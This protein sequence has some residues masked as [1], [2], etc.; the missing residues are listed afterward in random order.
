[1]YSRVACAGVVVLPGR[2]HEVDRLRVVVDVDR[3][4]QEV[5]VGADGL[6]EGRLV[7][8]ERG[9]RL[10]RELDR[11]ADLVAL[12]GVEVVVLVAAG[13]PAQGRRAL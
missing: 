9:G 4:G 8:D 3:D 1:M 2:G 6:G 10:D 7:E 11:G 13:V 12:A 5:G